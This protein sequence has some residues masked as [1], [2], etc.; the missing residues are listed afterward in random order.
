MLSQIEETLLKEFLAQ[1]PYP[2][3]TL[4]FNELMGFMYGLA[5]TPVEIPPEEWLLTIFGDDVDSVPAEARARG[6]NL[7]LSQV[8]ESFMARKMRGAL[9][10]PYPVENLQDKNLEELLEWSYGF[11]EA[12]ALRPEIWEPDEDNPDPDNKQEELFFSMMVI[13]GLNDPIEIMPFFEKI[14]AEIFSETFASFDPDDDDRELQ[15]Q[16]FL[17]ATLPLA[18]QTL[19]DYGARLQKSGVHVSRPAT[20]KAP[21]NEKNKPAK[22]KV[23]QVDFSKRKKK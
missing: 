21:I 12:L 22:G 4:S 9:H 15:V 16:A 13:Q 8:Y 1:I 11:E 6:M 20:T 18:V 10:F 17:I 3:Q 14:P 5:I 7:I 19:Q 2:E 23:I